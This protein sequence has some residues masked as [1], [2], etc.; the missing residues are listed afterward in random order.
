MNDR[1]TAMD[2][3]MDAVEAAVALMRRNLDSL[4]RESRIE[5]YRDPH[6]GE[7]DYSVR[8]KVA[9]NPELAP[10]TGSVAIDLGEPGSV[11]HL[12]P[13][14]F[15]HFVKT[16]QHPYIKDE[17]IKPT[18]F[19]PMH[20]ASGPNGETVINNPNA[21]PTCGAMFNRRVRHPYQPNGR[22]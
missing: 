18:P 21:K 5:E 2:A 15:D 1:L 8:K 22:R 12:T 10:W 19:D 16:C 11:I 3:T 6:K 4:V 20:Q 13:E 17:S 7:M 14:Q 9:A